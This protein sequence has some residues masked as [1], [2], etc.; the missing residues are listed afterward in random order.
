MKYKAGGF[1]VAVLYFQYRPV[2]PVSLQSETIVIMYG[3]IGMGTGCIFGLIFAI[4]SLLH[5]KGSYNNEK[6]K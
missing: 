4:T 2:I 6:F 5:L 1:T 3:I